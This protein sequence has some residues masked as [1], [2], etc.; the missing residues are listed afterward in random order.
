[1]KN[2]RIKQEFVTKKIGKIFKKN[3][4]APRNNRNWSLGKMKKFLRKAIRIM[5]KFFSEIFFF[6]FK[7]HFPFFCCFFYFFWRFF[8]DFTVFLESIKIY[9][10]NEYKLSTVH[11][12]AYS[13][14]I[15]NLLTYNTT[16]R[17]QQIEIVF[18]F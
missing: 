12:I 7:G 15:G 9:M 8:C 11:K 16:S 5:Y 4:M 14:V 10:K 1:M 6:I 18:C 13:F 3:E 2:L 17:H